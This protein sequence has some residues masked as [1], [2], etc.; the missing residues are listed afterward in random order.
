MSDA[1]DSFDSDT[2]QFVASIV[3]TLFLVPIV[4][5]WTKGPLPSRKMRQMEALLSETEHLLRSALQE[6]TITYDQY[7]KNIR[8]SMWLAKFQADE[9]RSQVYNITTAWQEFLHWTRGLSNRIAKVVKMLHSIRGEISRSSSKG[10][11]KLDKMGVTTDPTLVIYA[12]KERI[13]HLVLPVPPPNAAAVSPPYTDRDPLTTSD[14]TVSAPSCATTVSVVPNGTERVSRDVRLA[15]DPAPLPR[16]SF[17]SPA[18]ERRRFLLVGFGRRP[19][20]T[21]HIDESARSPPLPLPVKNTRPSRLRNIFGFLRNS[22][23]TGER[24]VLPRHR[25]VIPVHAPLVTLAS[26]L[27]KLGDDALRIWEKKHVVAQVHLPV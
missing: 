9:L 23:D 16:F 20:Y 22:S 18:N 27:E 10:R 7:D 13:S 24:D 26:D 6:G 3:S 17:P 19:D 25:D 2:W 4:Y 15:S 12:P 14:P 1:S 5:A 11:E 8:Q 21:T